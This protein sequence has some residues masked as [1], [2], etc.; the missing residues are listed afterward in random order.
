MARKV[1]NRKVGPISREYPDGKH[2]SLLQT[3]TYTYSSE[4]P[5]LEKEWNRRR[6][7]LGEDKSWNLHDLLNTW[8]NIATTHLENSPHDYQNFKNWELGWPSKES[9]AAAEL[10]GG[11]A[12]AFEILFSI[13]MIK[14]EIENEDMEK[15]IIFALRMASDATNLAIS[16]LEPLY[17][18]GVKQNEAANLDRIQTSNDIKEKA[19]PIF[20]QYIK[21]GNSKLQAAKLTSKWLNDKHNIERAKDTIRRWYE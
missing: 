12:A 20:E 18:A 6:K 10:D 15:A 2:H 5:Y 3:I 13:Y 16:N 19:H 11:F 9:K 1:S 17:H 8:K 4:N 7:D 21:K 14:R